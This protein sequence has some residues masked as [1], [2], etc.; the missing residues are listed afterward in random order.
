VDT[1]DSGGRDMC[2]DVDDGAR[3]LGLPQKEMP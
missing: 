3:N 1:Y 2:R